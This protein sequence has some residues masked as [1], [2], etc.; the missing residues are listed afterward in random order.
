MTCS[1]PRS[2]L[3]DSKIR[4]LVVDVKDASTLVD[5]PLLPGRVELSNVRV[6][7]YQERR[8]ESMFEYHHTSIQSLHVRPQKM[9][10]LISAYLS[11]EESL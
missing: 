4:P 5:V 8:F 10:I 2:S 6:L 7:G 1:Y 9:V 11:V 3:D